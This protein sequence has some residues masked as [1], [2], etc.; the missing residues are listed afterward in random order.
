MTK[1]GPTSN[2]V[3]AQGDSEYS[4]EGCIIHFGACSTL[5]ADSGQFLKDTRLDAI[6][7]YTDEVGWIDGAAMELLYL[8]CLYD[9]FGKNKNRKYLNQEIMREIRDKVVQSSPSKELANHTNFS[10]SVREGK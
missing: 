5:S 10:I 7:G 2:I 6:S 1:S 8:N 4:W 9:I 3:D